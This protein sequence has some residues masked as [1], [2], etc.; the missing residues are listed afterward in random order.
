MKSKTI[1]K[2][3]SKKFDAW[4]Q[5]ITDEKVR[6]L[7]EQNT[8]MTGGAITSM[9]LNEEVNDYDFYFRNKE[10]TLAVAQYYVDSFLKKSHEV[11][12]S[13]IDV[14]ISVKED[15]DRVKIVVKS[16]GAEAEGN[17]EP[18]R[19]FEAD[20]YPKKDGAGEYI[21]N[22]LNISNELK[23]NVKY[24]YRPVFISSNAIT[25]TGDVQIVIRFY[26]EP[27]QI[28]NNYDYVHCTNYWNSW[29]KE[30][31]LRPEAL[32]C[33][34]TKELRYIGS[35]YPVASV[36]RLRK[37]LDRGWHI[38]A[39]QLLKILIQVSELE[40]ERF[41]VFEEQLTGLDVAYFQEII[42]KMKDKDPTKVDY[43]YLSNLIDEIF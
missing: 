15:G 21:E 17:N 3:I 11:S 29:N 5:T 1:N 6:D 33:I 7:V 25:L 10:T 20:P 34:L 40:L 30:V 43:T 13:G 9:L 39:G 31:V 4:V 16:S 24:D 8:I 37:F 28:H 35:K 12:S 42:A 19:Y 18:Y 27:D 32:E 41:D 14:P 36:C 23:K 26:G 22:L 38:T 2:V